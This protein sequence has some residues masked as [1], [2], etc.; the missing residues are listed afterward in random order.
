MDS[1]VSVANA[2]RISNHRGCWQVEIDV[3]PQGSIKSPYYYSV[4]TIR[5]ACMNKKIKA[6]AAIEKALETE[7]QNREDLQNA[8]T[9][10]N[11]TLSELKKRLRA[12]KRK[13]RR[14][15]NKAL[16]KSA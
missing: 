1:F 16:A 13:S 6:K 14:L 10:V 7:K 15:R 9:K 2:Q 3:K 4:Y 12:S 11:S 8:I 5:L